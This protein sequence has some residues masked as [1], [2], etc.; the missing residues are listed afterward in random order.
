MKKK[1]SW[2]SNKDNTKNDTDNKKDNEPEKRHS[3]GKSNKDDDEKK[4]PS[5]GNNKWNTKND[6]ESKKK[7]NESETPITTNKEE[8]VAEKPRKIKVLMKSMPYCAS[9][10]ITSETVDHDDEETTE[11]K[12]HDEGKTMYPDPVALLPDEDL[13]H[14]DKATNANETQR[15]RVEVEQPQES[16]KKAPAKKKA[17]A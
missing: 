5:W 10:S 15:E 16:S 4:Q 3:W 2:G 14:I 7:D 13:F 6:T 17:P 12:L 1:W 9:G 11:E 8:E